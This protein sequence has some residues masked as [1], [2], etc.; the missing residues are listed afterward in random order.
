[1]SSRLSLSLPLAGVCSVSRAFFARFR[2]RADRATA[3][4]QQRFAVILITEDLDSWGWA[5]L[6]RTLG[7]APA[8]PRRPR[9]SPR[10][11]PLERA[12]GRW[13]A[14]ESLSRFRGEQPRHGNVYLGRETRSGHANLNT[15]DAGCGGG[16]KGCRAAAL[17]SPTADA[18]TWAQ[19]N[20]LL[21]VDLQLYDY[22]KQLA[23]ERMG[24]PGADAEPKPAG[25]RAAGGA[26]KDAARRA[27]QRERASHE[28]AFN[29][30]QPWL[31][32]H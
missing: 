2:A 17:I 20:A 9:K 18:P 32:P 5:A 6:H 11:E 8:A 31:R 29:A 30:G 23:V 27:H 3:T 26:S 16:G 28:R 4:R 25:R 12:E 1:M 24:A 7:F 14:A 15:R 10:S 13:S 22:A 19:L 21:D